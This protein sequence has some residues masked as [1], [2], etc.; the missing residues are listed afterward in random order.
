[1]SQIALIAVQLKINQG[2]E[3]NNPKRN[4]PISIIITLL[5]VSLCYCSTSI[6]LTLMMPYYLIDPFIP[7]P[8]AFDLAGFTW[9]KYIVSV[10]AIASLATW[11]LIL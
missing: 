11:Y 2:E 10:G 8:Q 1:M 7:F 3:V 9:E 6:V 5:T 4:I